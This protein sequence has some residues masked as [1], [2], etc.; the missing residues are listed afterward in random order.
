MQAITTKYIPANDHKGSKI[1]AT[2]CDGDKV[3]AS[4]TIGYHS[5]DGCP[6]EAACKALVEKL[7]MHGDWVGQHV[8][9]HVVVW[10]SVK[11][12]RRVSN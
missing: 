9:P 8:R 7:N 11:S 12:S 5:A 1:R 10:V 4:T 2:M 6:H 3:H